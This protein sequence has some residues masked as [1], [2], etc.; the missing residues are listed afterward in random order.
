MIDAQNDPTAVFIFEMNEDGTGL[1]VGP[2]SEVQLINQAS[3]C[4][5][6]WRVDTASIDTTAVFKGTILALNSITVA[7]GANIEGRLLAR[8]GNVTLIND[9]ITVPAACNT[10]PAGGSTTGTSPGFPNT[11]VD[12]HNSTPLYLIIPA[13][14]LVILTSLYLVRKKRAN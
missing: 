5:I 14:I 10:V 13:S 2:G 9:T 6:F 4:N 8:N 12:T 11:G 3:A 1:T 7:N